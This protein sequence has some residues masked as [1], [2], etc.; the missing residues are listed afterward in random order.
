MLPSEEGMSLPLGQAQGGGA[1]CPKSERSEGVGGRTSPGVRSQ[2]PFLPH[3]L[4]PD[5]PLGTLS[6]PHVFQGTSR[7][8]QTEGSSLPEGIFMRGPLLLE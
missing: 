4:G 2:R 1:I 8:L 5:T 6:T 7:G 3:S